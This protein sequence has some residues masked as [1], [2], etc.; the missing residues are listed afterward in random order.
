MTT[1]QAHFAIEYTGPILSLN[2]YKS[3]DWRA[4]RTKVQAVERAFTL[5]C[6]QRNPPKLSWM[7]L[8]VRHNTRLDMDNITGLIKPCVDVLRA[9]QILPDDCAR[10]WDTLTIVFDPAITKGLV[11]FE[12]LGEVR[13]GSASPVKRPVI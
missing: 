9:R 12:I 13:P 6:L 4:L 10:N 2:E 8:T 5:A 7:E 3:L 1:T 11:R